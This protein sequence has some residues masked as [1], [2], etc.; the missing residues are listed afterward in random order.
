MSDTP[1]NDRR[2]VRLGKGHEI[3]TPVTR[4]NKHPVSKFHSAI[5]NSE[6]LQSRVTQR[7]VEPGGWTAK[8]VDE[9]LT[10]SR[11][12]NGRHVGALSNAPLRDAHDLSVLPRDFAVTDAR[13]TGDQK[14]STAPQRSLIDLEGMTG[15]VLEGARPPVTDG[16]RHLVEIAVVP[17]VRVRNPEVQPHIAFLQ[18]DGAATTAPTANP[19]DVDVIAHGGV[20]LARTQHNGGDGH[21]PD[22]RGR[23]ATLANVVVVE[24]F[25]NDAC[26]EAR[27][28]NGSHKGS[29]SWR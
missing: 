24:E 13:E 7:G 6:R 3:A 15:D 2:E 27:G 12:K 5:E 11:V 21:R 16:A 4:V 29:E 22:E 19:R 1:E 25:L 8:V 17:L 14:L 26:H 28:R 10:R 23:L 9:P 18:Q 20:T